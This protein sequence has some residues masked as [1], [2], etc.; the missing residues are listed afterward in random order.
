M[1]AH[2]AIDKAVASFKAIVR[3]QI[4]SVIGVREDEDAWIVTLEV[5]QRKAIPDT[6]DV[7]GVYDVKILKDG[8]LGQ[9]ERKVLRKRG[10]IDNERL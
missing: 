9:I 10:E 2:E 1:D 8:K 7:L 6:Q 3:L 4:E 5:L